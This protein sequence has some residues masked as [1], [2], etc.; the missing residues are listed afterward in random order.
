MTDIY[1]Q[2]E[3]AL[4]RLLEDIPEKHPRRSDALVLKQRLHENIARTRRYGDTEAHRAERTQILDA[5]NQLALETTG[6]S[7]N[8]WCGQILQ[9][10]EEQRPSAQQQVTDSAHPPAPKYLIQIQQGNRIVIGDTAQVTQTFES[11]KNEIASQLPGKFY[12]ELVGRDA[13]V[14]AVMAALRD[15]GGKW[16]V[17][18]DGMGGI[19]KTALAREIADRCL[20]ERLFDGVVWEQ[21]P[22]EQFARGEQGQGIG[23]LTYETALDSIARQLGALDVP[24]LKGAEKETRVRALLQTQRARGGKRSD[25]ILTQYKMTIKDWAWVT[26]FVVLFVGAAVAQYGFG[27]FRLI[28]SPLN[29]YLRTLLGIG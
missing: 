22:K 24:R 4:N 11:P 16:I 6:K 19:G 1:H 5:L 25:Y 18:I 3:A 29:I 2:Y 15:P 14:G 12:R 20:A 9:A 26:I 21:A 7:F 23:M 10:Q 17:A 13:L 8:D 27:T 28:H